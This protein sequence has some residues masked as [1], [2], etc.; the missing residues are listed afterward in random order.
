[1]GTYN[2]HIIK[3]LCSNSKFKITLEEL[4]GVL[5]VHCDVFEYKKSAIRELIDTFKLLGKAAADSGYEEVAAYTLN[6]RFARL[7]NNTFELVGTVPTKNG[8][9][10]E[11]LVWELK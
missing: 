11:V 1:M 6:K 4:D 2:N 5:F 8:E 7:M 9:V 10:F 3:E